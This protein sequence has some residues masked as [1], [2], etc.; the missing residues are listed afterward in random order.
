MK[1]NWLLLNATAETQGNI[2]EVKNLL[3]SGIE[4]I[5]AQAK[6]FGEI[7]TNLK[8]QADEVAKLQKSLDD[9]RKAQIAQKA[10]APALRAAAARR[11]VPTSFS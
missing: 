9:V 10:S 3:Q 2:T 1:R 5:D 4:K 7:E 8:G 11:T 6:K